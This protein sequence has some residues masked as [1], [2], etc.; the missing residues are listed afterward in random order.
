MNAVCPGL[1]AVL[2]S[3]PGH[4]GWT[5]VYLPGLDG[6]KHRRQGTGGVE[7]DRRPPRVL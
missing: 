4:L 5:A 1:T 3:S 7:K 6:R 2:D